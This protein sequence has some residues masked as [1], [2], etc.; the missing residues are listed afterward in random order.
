MQ[1]VYLF[2]FNHLLEYLFHLRSP[3][4]WVIGNLRLGRPL[5]TNLIN[6]IAFLV[7]VST[8]E[9]LVLSSVV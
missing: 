1:F 4:Y 5:D 8:F 6:L 3:L 9:F 2:L 7:F